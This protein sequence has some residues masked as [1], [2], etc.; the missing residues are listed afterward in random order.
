MSD[1][2]YS[3]NEEKSVL[4]H[5]SE[6]SSRTVKWDDISVMVRNKQRLTE[7]LNTEN[8]FLRSFID[9]NR[10]NLEATETSVDVV[11]K[12]PTV[13]MK[14]KPSFVERYRLLEAEQKC[15][16]LYIEKELFKQKIKEYCSK[17]ERT[18]EMLQAKMEA[19]AM[20]NDEIQRFYDECRS[21]V[22]TEMVH[23]KRIYVAE[24][25]LRYHE[26]HELQ[27][28]NLIYTTRLQNDLLRGNIRR[29]RGQ[30]W[31][32]EEDDRPTRIDFEAAQHANRM[33]S[34]QLQERTNTLVR[35]KQKFSQLS[36]ELCYR[37]DKLNKLALENKKLAKAYHNKYDRTS[38]LAIGLRNSLKVVLDEGMLNETLQNRIK[39][40][41]APEVNAF[42]RTL[43]TKD[44]IEREQKMCE[45]RR[46]I[47][48]IMYKQQRNILSKLVES[49]KRQT[50]CGC[51]NNYT[52]DS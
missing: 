32:A 28:N 6:S 11:S 52:E 2:P 9:R 45:R 21:T 49:E 17:C 13:R 31:S 40:N 12:R 42:V 14:S 30:I 4:S 7:Q 23:G 3:G 1:P 47:A 39:Y 34:E 16:V 10:I 29:L 26:K 27:R 41:H 18:L 44:V 25:F 48:Q 46:R 35:T 20:K 15:Y 38:S 37:K 8:E 33:Q 24:T 50:Y 5:N 22:T 43:I 51:S 36:L 19:D